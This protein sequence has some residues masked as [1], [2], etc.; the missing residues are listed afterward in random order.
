MPT[1]RLTEGP[2]VVVPAETFALRVRSQTPGVTALISATRDQVDVAE[3]EVRRPPGQEIQLVIGRLNEPLVLALKPADG[4]VFPAGCVLDVSL[5]GE[6]SRSTDP[7]RIIVGSVDADQ[8]FHTGVDVSGLPQH[9]VLE[10]TPTVTTLSVRAFVGRDRLPEGLAKKAHDVA[11]SLLQRDRLTAA[12]TVDLKVIVDSSASMRQWAENGLLGK[13][14]DLIGGIDHVIGGDSALDIR[15]SHSRDWLLVSA[16][17][18]SKFA[19]DLLSGPF[20]TG[21]VEPLPAGDQRTATL[22]VTDIVPRD[23]DPTPRNCCVV[24]CHS[25]AETYLATGPGVVGIT[26]DTEDPEFPGAATAI[27]DTVAAILH[28][29][30]P[31]HLL[32][33]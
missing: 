12:D 27:T 30:L 9:A 20:R 17:R 24:L 3:P 33:A 16:D 2:T 19:S 1:Y 26:A 7:H 6:F 21:L 15:L 23:W 10:L 8:T 32:G 31:D 22:L 11:R 29:V 25:G 4:T 5:S 28:A 14:L 13:S 18:A